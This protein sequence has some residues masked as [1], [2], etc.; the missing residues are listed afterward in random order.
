MLSVRK[1]RSMPLTSFE[2]NEEVPGRSRA[3][4]HFSSKP[5]EGAFWLSRVRG[6]VASL[7]FNKMPGSK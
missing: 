6:V 3:I 2:M 5:Q 7:R 4:G 1:G